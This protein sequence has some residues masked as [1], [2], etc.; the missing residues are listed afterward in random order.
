MSLGNTET[1]KNP[2]PDNEVSLHPGSGKVAAIFSV[3]EMAAVYETYDQQLRM[4]QVGELKEVLTEEE[5]TRTERLME[6]Y[7]RVC[8]SAMLQL[9]SG[10]MVMF[11]YPEVQVGEC[12][13]TLYLLH[14]GA[15]V[16][17]G[18][19]VRDAVQTSYLEQCADLAQELGKDP[20]E[21]TFPDLGHGILTGSFNPRPELS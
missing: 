9:V 19:D 18:S 1:G 20:S 3:M 14:I 12:S 4:P 6:T 7:E 17:R 8:G 15:T 16:H 5:V 13:Q 21:L 11:Q 2:E 10:P